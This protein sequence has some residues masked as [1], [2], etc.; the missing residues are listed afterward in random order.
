[1]RMRV[2]LVVSALIACSLATCDFTRGQNWEC[3]ACGGSASCTCSGSEC[4]VTDTVDGCE[5]PSD[6]TDWMC[7]ANVY[8]SG[9]Q[10]CTPQVSPTTLSDSPSNQRQGSNVCLGGRDC[11]CVGFAIGSVCILTLVVPLLVC[12]LCGSCFAVWRLRS[13]RS[14]ERAPLL[15]HPVNA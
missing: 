7:N 6:R 15:D 3:V 5:L 12:G 14:E 10:V 13:R 9:S 8:V 2:L 11:D 4:C 1:M